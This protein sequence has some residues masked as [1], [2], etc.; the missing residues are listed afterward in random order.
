MTAST[1]E[2][3]PLNVYG[4]IGAGLFVFLGNSNNFFVNML[5]LA[6]QG[7]TMLFL[8]LVFAT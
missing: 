5:H 2:R 3:W 4:N 1:A 7:A 8:Y 6:L